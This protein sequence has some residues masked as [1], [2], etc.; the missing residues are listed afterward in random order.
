MKLRCVLH[1][2][3]CADDSRVDYTYHQGSYQASEANG[4]HHP[5]CRFAMNASVCVNFVPQDSGAHLPKEPIPSRGVRIC[6]DLLVR[7][8]HIVYHRS[9]QDQQLGDPAFLCLKNTLESP[10]SV[11]RPNILPTCAPLWYA[12]KIFLL[13]P[14]LYFTRTRSATFTNKFPIHL[15]H[16]YNGTS[17]GLLR[18]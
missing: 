6:G 13:A 7:C 11:S 10:S 15:Q 4:A 18:W 3:P 17:C 14:R 8:V 1:L 12:C 9:E 16:F 5:R 2:T